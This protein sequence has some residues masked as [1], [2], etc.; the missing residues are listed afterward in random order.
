MAKLIMHRHVRIAFFRFPLVNLADMILRF[1]HCLS[2]YFDDN[3]PYIIA[4]AIHSHRHT[5]VA[6]VG[7]STSGHHSSSLFAHRTP[8]TVHFIVCLLR[9]TGPSKSPSTSSSYTTPA[10]RSATNLNHAHQHH[11]EHRYDYDPVRCPTTPV[12]VLFVLAFVS[13]DN[14]NSPRMDTPTPGR[15]IRV[16]RCK[17]MKS[18]YATRCDARDVYTTHRDPTTHPIHA[19]P[20]CRQPSSARS[21]VYILYYLRTSYTSSRIP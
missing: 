20:F 18:S 19:R 1:C 10:T 7:L 12:T 16:D 9:P 4:C 6:G 15:C 13:H 21:I 8:P 14:F 11:C 2:T 5:F 17:G 3:S